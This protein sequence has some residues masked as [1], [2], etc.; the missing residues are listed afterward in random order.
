M[1]KYL[2]IFTIIIIPC[3]SHSQDNEDCFVRLEKAFKERG[4]LPISND[5][6][7]GVI[8][9]FFDEDRTRCVEGKVRVEN[10]T[11]VDI[12]LLFEDNTFENLNKKFYSA[13]KRTPPIITNG[14]S[15]LIQTSDGQDKFKVVFIGKLKPKKKAYKEINL[16]DDL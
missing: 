12:F 5:V 2:L 7:Q 13:A 10:G 9:S 8:I 14:I 6:H 1:K 4:S 11:I 3:F 16:P 15:E